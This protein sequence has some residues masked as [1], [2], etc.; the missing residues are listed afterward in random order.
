[1]LAFIKEQ[2]P[3]KGTLERDPIEKSLYLYIGPGTPYFQKLMPVSVPYPENSHFS[4]PLSLQ[5]PVFLAHECAKAK[6]L[7]LWDEIG[8]EFLFEVTGCYTVDTPSHPAMRSMVL[9]L[10]SSALEHLRERY[11][12]SK[13]VA[14]HSFHATLLMKKRET[15]PKPALCRLNVSCF[16]A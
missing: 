6:N 16:A 15:P 12:L 1:M 10:R 4:H 7:G 9:T 11:L 3:Q 8:K 13:A 14:G 5:A 2:L